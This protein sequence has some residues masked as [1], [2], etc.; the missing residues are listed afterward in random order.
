[1]LKAE[2]IIYSKNLTAVV[3]VERATHVLVRCDITLFLLR[4]V[5]FD[6]VIFER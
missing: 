1:M 3:G 5:D 6:G 2:G 4:I